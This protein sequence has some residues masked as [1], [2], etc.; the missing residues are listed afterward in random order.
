MY[1]CAECGRIFDEP[2]TTSYES[3]FWGA[4]GF[5]D[6]WESPCCHSWFTEIEESE[7]DDNV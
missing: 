7:D 5:T 4:P 6:Y 3:E 1:R 2:I